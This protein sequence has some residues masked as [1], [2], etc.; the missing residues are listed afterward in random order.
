MRLGSMRG[1][2]GGFPTP[3]IML[4]TYIMWSHHHTASISHF[5]FKPLTLATLASILTSPH[6]AGNTCHKQWP[7]CW[8]HPQAPQVLDA[9]VVVTA[10]EARL[11]VKVILILQLL[12]DVLHSTRT[13]TSH[14]LYA[15]RHASLG[16]RSTSTTSYLPQQYMH[17]VIPP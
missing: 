13:T 5:Q 4:M 6:P 14:E 2:G 3:S 17:H 16:L 10:V 8:L 11:P 9:D 1:G 15:P 7:T 12:P